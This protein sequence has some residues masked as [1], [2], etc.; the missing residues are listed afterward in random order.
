VAT[1]PLC[2]SIAPIAIAGGIGSAISMPLFSSRGGLLGTLGLFHHAPGAP[3]LDELRVLELASGLAAIA[4]ER[5]REEEQLQKSEGEKSLLLSAIPDMMFRL[6]RGGV[7]L[8]CH[9]SSP[10][11]LLL[12]PGQFLGKALEQVLPPDLA[13][14]LRGRLDQ[15]FSTGLAQDTEY[16]LP[17]LDGPAEYEARY[18]KTAGGDALVIVR[19]ITER[20]RI[21]RALVSSEE[22]YRMLF[23]RNLAGVYHSTEDGKLLD[24]NEAFARILG[25]EARGEALA[26]HASAFYQSPEQR[27]EFLSRLRERN[28]LTNSELRLVKRDGTLVWLLE[29]ASLVPGEG[30]EPGRIFGSLVDITDRKRAEEQLERLAYTDVLTGLPNAHLFNDRLEM[31][32]NQAPYTGRTVSVLFLDLDRFKVINDSLGHRTGDVLL[33]Q[34]AERLR[35]TVYEA[36]TVARL[37]GDE[38]LILLPRL[39]SLKDVTRVAQKVLSRFKQPFAVDG[40]DLFMSMSMGIAVYPMDGETAEALVKNADTAMFRAKQTG[41]DSYQ[42]YTASMNDRA[43]ERVTLET[44]LHKALDRG[45]FVLHYQPLVDLAAGTIDGVEALI[46]WRHRSRGLIP[47]A[48]FIPLAEETGLIVPIGAWVLRTACLQARAWQMRLKRPMRVAVNLSA[49]QFRHPE[50]VPQVAQV[51]E[52]TELAP[53]LLELEITETIAMH[54]VGG[55]QKTLRE[56]KALGVRITLDDFGTGYSSLSYL[57]TFPIDSLKIDRSFIQDITTSKSDVA[58]AVASI[59]FAH[60]LD[61]RAIA[62]GVETHSQLDILRLHDCDAMQGFLVSRPL[63]PDEFETIFGERITSGVHRIPEAASA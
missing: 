48:E 8:D 47:P 32:L 28:S 57:K 41:R 30:G 56:L 34:V 17:G 3:R 26:C 36:D 21:E 22:R 27:E 23:D 52:E 51:L 15:L 40:R 54:D 50:L 60:G 16:T 18:S 4:I 6:D 2:E 37:G 29:N 35:G 53:E 11:K 9:A 62:E 63:P 10:E 45:E 58:I 19:D 39:G 13:V 46:R 33:T 5:Q 12:P 55:S 44:N 49:R 38:F 43:V 24:C 14:G 61:L 59:A 20:K 7:F 25:F 31:A 42:Y 1:D